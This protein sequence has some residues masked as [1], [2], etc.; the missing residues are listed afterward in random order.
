MRERFPEVDVQQAPAELLPYPDDAFDVAL[1]QLV[2]L[3]MS[4]PGAGV[5]E[6]VRVTRPDGVVAAC[7]WD[8]A[9]GQGPLSLFW[10]AA[11]ELDPNVE[12]ESTLAGTGEG[13]ADG[14]VHCGRAARC[15]GGHALR[16]SRALELRRVVGA[17]HAGRRTGG[18][19]RRQ[20]L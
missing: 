18:R 19:P 20:P 1:A 6:M 2:V 16:R 12:D 8:H 7:V 3:F 9:G 17:V 15:R 5:A 11:R 13:A 4:D 10:R 14:V